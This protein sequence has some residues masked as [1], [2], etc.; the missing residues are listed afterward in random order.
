MKWCSCMA[1][2]HYQG[3]PSTD[4]RPVNVLSFTA[5]KPPAPSSERQH[6]SPSNPPSRMTHSVTNCQDYIR[7]QN[8]QNGENFKQV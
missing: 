8:E 2:S 5:V 1:G 4:R 3:V 6:K 7:L